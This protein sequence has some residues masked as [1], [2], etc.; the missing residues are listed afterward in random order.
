VDYETDTHEVKRNGKGWQ[1][2]EEIIT[3]T[4]ERGERHKL[5]GIEIS[6]NKYFDTELLRSRLQIFGGAF[7]SRGRFSRRLVESDRQSMQL[8]YQ[9]NGFLDAQV[10]AEIEDN[11]EGKD[12]DLLIH[13]KVQEGADACG[14]T[15]DRRAFMLLRKRNFSA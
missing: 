9:A 11:Y 1:G 13:F 14:L 8:L 6:G 3:Y 5:M 15:F 2:T 4:V 10:E 7:A 12:G